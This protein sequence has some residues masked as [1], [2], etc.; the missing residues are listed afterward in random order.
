MRLAITRAVS[1]DMAQCQLTHLPRVAIDLGQARDQHR[2]YQAALCRLG[3]EVVE[4]P[5]APAAPD[6]VFI[7]DTALVLDEVAVLCRPGAECVQER[8]LH[9]ARNIPLPT[10]APRPDSRS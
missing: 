4:I 9:G 3:C 7:E 6:S 8:E 1:P 5:A 2:D 10:R